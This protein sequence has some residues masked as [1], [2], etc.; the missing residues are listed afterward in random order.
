MIQF[1]TRPL[2]IDRP[3]STGSDGRSEDTW[4]LV[5]ELVPADYRASLL[6]QAQAKPKSSRRISFLRPVRKKQSKQQQ[7]PAMPEISKPLGF[8]NRSS[9]TINRSTKASLAQ[10]RQQS[11]LGSRSGSPNLKTPDDSV[12]AGGPTK[13]I[14][15]SNSILSPGI[16]KASSLHDHEEEI[17]GIDASPVVVDKD[18]AKSFN[19]DKAGL[20]F[21]RP[22]TSSGVATSSGFLDMMRKT[23]RRNPRRSLLGTSEITASHDGDSLPSSPASTVVPGS[24]G[25]NL[26]EHGVHGP[27][28]PMDN[29]NVR[30]AMSAIC[31]D[32]YLPY[33]Y[34][35]AN[36]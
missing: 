32:A 7:Q 23:T 15:L 22:P 14:K 28:R 9:E 11:S 17:D 19:Q 34:V 12:F 13:V 2:N 6:A 21:S 16:S 1:R 36:S 24:P 25:F 30:V 20:G 35:F 3:V 29:P 5:E 26:S 4:F 31:S 33:T 18:D 10:F 27:G 8:F